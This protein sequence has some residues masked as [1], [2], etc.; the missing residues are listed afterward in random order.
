MPG[1]LV[2]RCGSLASSGCPVA[3]CS[4]STTQLLLPMPVDRGRAAPASASS[5]ARRSPSAAT[6]SR[7]VRRPRGMRVPG[8]VASGSKTPSTT[9][10]LADDRR[11]LVVGVGAGR[12]RRPARACGSPRASAR[13]I[14]SLHVAAQVPGHRLEPG[15]RVDRRPLLGLVVEAADARAAVYSSASSRGRAVV[16][17]GVDALGCTP[18][19]RPGSRGSSSASSARPPAASPRADDLVGL[20]GVSPNSSES[21]P[22]VTCRRTSISKKRSWACTKPWASIRSAMV[23]A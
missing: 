5:P 2:P 15:E 13:S 4:P 22:A 10:A 21:R 17:V 20:E 16:E 9:R 3:E 23:S 11:V 14:S 8:P 7:G 1:R 6:W 19:A 12:A 18:R